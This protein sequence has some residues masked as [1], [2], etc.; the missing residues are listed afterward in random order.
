MTD[1]MSGAENV[2]NE[3]GKFVTPENKKAIKG[4][5]DYVKTTQQQS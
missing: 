5:E 4:C 2:Q 1:F 3:P